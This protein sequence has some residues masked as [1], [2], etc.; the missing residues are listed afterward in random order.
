MNYEAVAPE[1]VCEGN[2]P[3]YRPNP[4]NMRPREV[5]TC[6]WGVPQERDTFLL[7]KWLL[8]VGTLCTSYTMCGPCI[9]S[10]WWLTTRFML[11]SP[12]WRH[13]RLK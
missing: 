9:N 3:F 10:L 2:L 8:T 4:G 13:R 7:S 5:V 11:L 1:K 6:T 12:L